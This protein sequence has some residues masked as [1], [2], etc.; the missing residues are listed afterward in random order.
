MFDLILAVEV[1]IALAAILALRAVARSSSFVAEEV[2]DEVA[3][4]P[5]PEAL[6]PHREAVLLHQR[7]LT[8]RLDGALFFGASQRF[9]AELTSVSVVRV[10]ILRM[11]QLQVLD[12]TGAQAL[13]E[14]ISELEGRGIT[15]LIKG[16]RAE[17]VRVLR[18]VGALDHLRHENHLFDSLD[19]AVA[20]ARSHVE[21]GMT[22]SGGPATSPAAG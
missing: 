1:G 13:G 22:S 18:A 12:A 19:A 6:T 20:H 11:P 8:Y 10:V 7:I 9:L 14:L 2:P 4:S 17:H 21:R 15:V 3:G 16:P 5:D